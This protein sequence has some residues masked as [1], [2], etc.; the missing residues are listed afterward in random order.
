MHDVLIIGSGVIGMSI[1]RHLSATHLDV[2]VIDRDVPGKHASYKAGGMLGAQNEFTEDS[3]LFQLAIESRAM[4]PQLSKSLL[5]ETGIDIQFKNSGLIKIANEHDDIS[6]IKRQYQFL[7]SQDRSVKQLSDDDLLQLTHGEVKP[8]YAA[9]HIPHDGQ[10]NAHHYTL[11]LLE[12]M[13][14]RDIKRYESTEVTSIE[15]HNGYYSV[16]T[17]QSSTI[18]AHKIIVAGGAW[19]SQLLTQY[20][21][22]DWLLRHAYHRVPQLKDSHILKKWSGVRPYTEKEMPVMDQIDDGLYVISGHYRNGILLSPIIGRD[23]ANWLLSGIKPSRYS[24]F[25]VTRRN[26]HEVYH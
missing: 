6:S 25:T 19:S 3:D 26:N 1:A 14:L 17:D 13:K 16:K 21:G 8:S 24:S 23:I 18:E 10:I 9:I 22:M 7:N 11:A 4:F 20:E 5:D 2:A 12:S 15:R